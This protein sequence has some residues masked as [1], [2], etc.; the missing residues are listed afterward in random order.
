M[1]RLA[2]EVMMHSGCLYECVQAICMQI[3][4]YGF[5]PPG[6]LSVTALSALRLKRVSRGD[7][8]RCAEGGFFRSAAGRR[9]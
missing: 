2:S 1:R 8:K 7:N 3:F 4:T 9:V 6:K 5:W